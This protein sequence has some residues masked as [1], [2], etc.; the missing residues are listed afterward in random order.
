MLKIFLYIYIVL[1]N[2]KNKFENSIYYWNLKLIQCDI[3][4]YDNF[5]IKFFIF[6][7]VENINIVVFTQKDIC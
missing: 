4:L 5:I 3:H 1:T 6:W 7:I 2:N